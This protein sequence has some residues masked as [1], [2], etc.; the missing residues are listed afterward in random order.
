MPLAALA[1]GA[2]AGT[3]ALSGPAGAETTDIVRT[4]ASEDGY[5]SSSRPTY[6][7]G[8]SDTLYL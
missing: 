5:S 8:T 6:T 4:G 3:V 2:A 7:F 1:I